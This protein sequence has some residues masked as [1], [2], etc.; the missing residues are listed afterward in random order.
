[1]EIGVRMDNLIKALKENY[2]SYWCKYCGRHLQNLE[3][4]F[5]HDNKPHPVDYTPDSGEEHRLQ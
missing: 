1:M 2:N 4:V 3:G 5:V